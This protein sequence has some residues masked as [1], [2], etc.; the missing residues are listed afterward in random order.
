MSI[1]VTFLPPWP[2]ELKQPRATK[3]QDASTRAC[4]VAS[5][6]FSQVYIPSPLSN[7]STL[8][9]DAEIS[10]TWLATWCWRK[11]GGSAD[12]HDHS[13]PSKYRIADW[14]A[15]CDLFSWCSKTSSKRP[16]TR[17]TKHA[18]E[19]ASENTF[20]ITHQ[21]IGWRCALRPPKSKTILHRQYKRETMTTL[22]MKSAKEKMLVIKKIVILKETLFNTRLKCCFWRT[23][24]LNI[25]FPQGHSGTPLASYDKRRHR[26]CFQTRPYA[27]QAFQKSKHL[28]GSEV[29]WCDH[30]LAQTPKEAFSEVR[31]HARTTQVDFEVDR[32]PPADSPP[33]DLLITMVKE[34][35]MI[36]KKRVS[37]KWKKSETCSYLSLIW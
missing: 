15:G 24:W 37:K 29:S 1:A 26:N 11:K 28:L 31:V 17:N 7:R 16:A 6:F 23:A 36:F 12:G 5:T 13:S 25:C 18:I 32:L 33:G 19:Q 22:Q 8:L 14:R 10:A 4:A 9:V 20:R 3:V 35:V 2:K 27:L 21:C 30:R 34:T